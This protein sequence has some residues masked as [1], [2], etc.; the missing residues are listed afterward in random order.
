VTAPLRQLSVICAALAL[1]TQAWSEEPSTF[2]SVDRVSPH[3]MSPQSGLKQRLKQLAG[4]NAVNC[5]RASQS[6]LPA[7]DVT[8]CAL[9]EYTSAKRFYA[10]FDLEGW[11]GWEGDL[12]VGYASD[13]KKVYVVTSSRRPTWDGEDPPSF[14][15]QV[16]TCP[17]P[18]KLM[19]TPSGLLDCFVADPSSRPKVLQ[20]GQGY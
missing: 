13:G 3:W 1:A 7:P 12:E 15:L 10:R 19:K 8:E 20:T 4:D 18:T 16:Y 17:L 11:D 9:Q 5:G 14:L 2:I 6:L